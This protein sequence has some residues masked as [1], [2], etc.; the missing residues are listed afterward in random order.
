MF[1]VNLVTVS[2]VSELI[3]KIRDVRD[4]LVGQQ[5][6]RDVRDFLVGQKLVG[7]KI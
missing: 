4:F 1:V 3:K 2:A 5:K 6:I 7:Q